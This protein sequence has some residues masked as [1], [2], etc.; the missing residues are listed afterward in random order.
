MSTTYAQCQ[1]LVTSIAALAAQYC[2]EELVLGNCVYREHQQQEIAAAATTT[3]NLTDAAGAAVVPTVAE[4]TDVTATVPVARLLADSVFL[5][6][7]VRTLAKKV[8]DLVD[9]DIAGQYSSFNVAAPLGAAATNLTD[10]VITSAADVFKTGIISTDPR[11]LA[12]KDTAEA[13]RTIRALANLADQTKVGSA[14]V[15][16]ILL[17]DRLPK[18]RGFRIVVSNKLLTTGTGPF[19]TQNIAFARSGIG[20]VTV[21]RPL[22]NDATNIQ[23]MSEISDFGVHVRLAFD[24]S[25]TQVIGL[26]ARGAAIVARSGYGVQVKS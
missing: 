13:W 5:Q 8:A 18:Y 3:L 6:N 11:Y 15:Q 14:T 2:S 17:S 19:T 7:T 9:T 25:D 4:Y 16:S 23:V 21:R 26:R 24:G 22:T 20:L 1:Q 12:L 10:A